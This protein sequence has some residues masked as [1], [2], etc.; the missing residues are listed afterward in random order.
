MIANLGSMT[1]SPDLARQLAAAGRAQR[2][3]TE[4]RDE[5][6]REA[7]RQGASLREI[8]AAVGLSNPGVLRIIRRGQDEP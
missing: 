3:G 8:A 7:S 5:L 2:R 4:K 6:I 1:L